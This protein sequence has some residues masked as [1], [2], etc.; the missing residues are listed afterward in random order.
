[1][2]ASRHL[3]QLS[4]AIRRLQLPGFY[5]FSG[6]QHNRLHNPYMQLARHLPNL[7]GLSL[8]MHTAG[9]TTSAFT[10]RQM[11]E[12]ETY[13]PARSKERRCMR[14][15]DVVAKYELDALLQCRALQRLRIEYVECNMTRHFCRIGNPV[16]VLQGIR[17]RLVDGFARQGQNVVVDLSAVV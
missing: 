7:R 14:V 5:W 9:V 6:V 4:L 12:I 11:I 15:V 10:E 13:D 2:F 17:A 3:P 16:N 1:M 8:K